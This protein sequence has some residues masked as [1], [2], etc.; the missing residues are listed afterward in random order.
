MVSVPAQAAGKQTTSGIAPAFFTGMALR[1][2]TD[3]AGRKWRVWDVSAETIHPATRGEDYMRNY[4]G[5]WLA[6]ESADGLAKCRLTPIPKGWASAGG[7]QLI[8]W[9]HAA[10]TV[11]GDRGSGPHGRAVA[12]ATASPHASSDGRVA[13]RTFRF[14]GGRFWTV[15]EYDVGSPPDGGSGSDGG[16]RVLRFMSG[17]RALDVVHWP[18]DWATRPDVE[19]AELLSTSFPRHGTDSEDPAQQRRSTD[20]GQR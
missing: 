19:L 15:T 7:G 20:A 8:E 5:G 2:F 16:R 11:R 12:E 9:L 13:V 3:R 1:D 17:S 6:F 4:L 10:E 18:A 14:P